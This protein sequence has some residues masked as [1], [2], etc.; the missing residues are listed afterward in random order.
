[1][2][3]PTSVPTA[4]HRRLAVTTCDNYGL[5][6]KLGSSELGLLSCAG[7]LST[8][9]VSPTIYLGVSQKVTFVGGSAR[10]GKITLDD[11]R[12]AVLRDTTVIGARRGTTAVRIAASDTKCLGGPVDPV[13]GARCVAFVLVV[14]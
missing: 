10:G 1:V 9:M 2:P 13:D 3:A 6:V 8:A 11:P 5:A 7:F 12:L 4:S 14:R